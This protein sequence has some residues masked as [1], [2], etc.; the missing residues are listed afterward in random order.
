[1]G[2]EDRTARAAGYAGKGRRRGLTMEVMTAAGC[3]CCCLLLRQSGESYF[4]CAHLSHSS[5]R[6]MVFSLSLVRMFCVSVYSTV[7]GSTVCM[8]PSCEGCGALSAPYYVDGGG[9]VGGGWWRATERRRAEGWREG[10]C[11]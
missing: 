11:G 3:V 9:V 8:A 4:G 5:S 6:G 2:V 10:G 7:R 1:M